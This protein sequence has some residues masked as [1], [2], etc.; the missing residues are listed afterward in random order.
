[1][2]RDVAAFDEPAEDIASRWRARW[3]AKVVERSVDVAL[4]AVP[5][6]LRVLDVGCGAGALVRELAERLPNVLDLIGVDPSERMLQE[7]AA[8]SEGGA[9]FVC[10][11]IE[12]LPFADARFDLIV[13]TAL[14]DH[15]GDQ[16]PGLAEAAR[17]LAS[18]GHLVLVD[19]SA[20]WL[21]MTGERERAQ[22]PREVDDLLTAAGLQRERRETVCRAGPLPIARAFIAARQ[23]SFT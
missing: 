14:L 11:H 16:A 15:S 6:P 3:Q 10:A 19:L 20:G 9:R 13:S 21:R 8:A 2:D 4:A 5:V 18:P 7:A 22:P 1:L 23:V 12:R 17:V